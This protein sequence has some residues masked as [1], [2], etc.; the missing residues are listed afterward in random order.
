MLK[1]L[2]SSDLTDALGFALTGATRPSL[3]MGENGR[4]NS[5]QSIFVIP[6]PAEESLTLLAP[7]GSGMRDVST[8]L[9]MTIRRDY[10]GYK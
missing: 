9:D 7:L 3:R 4:R 8:P 10:Q 1:G 6:S 2:P 5:R